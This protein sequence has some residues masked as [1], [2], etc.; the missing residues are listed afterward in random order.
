MTLCAAFSVRQW[1]LP[2]GCL[3]SDGPSRRRAVSR[4]PMSPR[5]ES[6]G[7]SRKQCFGPGL[8][9][10][11]TAR[12]LLVPRASASV[13]G[14]PKKLTSGRSFF[15]AD[16]P[17]GDRTILPAHCILRPL[18]RPMNNMLFSWAE[19]WRR[20]RSLRDPGFVNPTGA[21]EPP[22]NSSRIVQGTFV[23]PMGARE[24]TRGCSP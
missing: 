13:R 3:W 24:C 18:V 14:G 15:R 23:L 2:S 7:Q 8:L 20:S 16:L 9:I 1:S 6:Q 12:R 10:G 21:P 5:S 22:G 11:E 17:V 19:P 4:L